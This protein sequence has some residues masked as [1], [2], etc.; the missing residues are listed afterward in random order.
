[1][2]KVINMTENTTIDI[3]QLR[4]LAKRAIL[5]MS[6]KQLEMLSVLYQKEIENEQRRN[7]ECN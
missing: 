2:K 7:H 4:N 5:S 6:D 1:M 3:E